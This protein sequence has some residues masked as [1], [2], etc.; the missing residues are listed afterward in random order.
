ML[1]RFA[2][3]ALGLTAPAVRADTVTPDDV[4]DLP[5]A[6]RAIYIGGTGD[7]RAETLDG[8]VVTFVAM[9]A[10]AIYPLRLRRVLATGTTATDLLALS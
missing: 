2:E 6:S 1:D 3:H 4:A 9:Q 7:V 10:G 5:A 8:D